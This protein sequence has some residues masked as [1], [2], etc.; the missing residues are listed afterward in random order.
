[1]KIEIIR[2][3]LRCYA[4]S[5]ECSN[6]E[7]TDVFDALE[8]LAQTEDRYDDRDLWKDAIEFIPLPTL[9]DI[10]NE[11][12]YDDYGRRARVHKNDMR[13]ELYAHDVREKHMFGVGY[14]TDSQLRAGYGLIDDLWHDNEQFGAHNE[15]GSFK[16]EA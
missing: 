14:L 13:F 6:D 15:D 11:L 4:A 2:K 3:A 16:H 10:L 5:A 8:A 1:M 7:R 9:I 12:T